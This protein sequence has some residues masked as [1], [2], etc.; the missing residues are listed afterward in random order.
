MC[1]FKK[2]YIDSIK[3][4]I[5]QNTFNIN[6]LK[7]SDFSSGNITIPLHL[8]FFDFSKILFVIPTNSN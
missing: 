2:L 8:V 1:I 4:I 6:K 7:K 3:I 5:S